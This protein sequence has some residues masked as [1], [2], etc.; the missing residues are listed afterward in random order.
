M[1]A[2]GQLA[3]G[4]AHDF[5]NL[6]TAIV[7][8]TEFSL[9][10]AEKDE[11]LTADL[12][13][14]QDA[15]NRARGLTAQLLAF[16][17]Q[18]M[19]QPRSLCLNDT[20]SG[21]VT[22]LRRLIG[23]H[24]EFQTHFEPALKSVLADPGQIEQVLVNL[25]VNARDAMPQGGTMTIETQNI[26][27]DRDLGSLAPGDYVALV[28]SDTGEGMAAKTMARIFDPFYTTKE[29]GQGT[30]LG[31]STV[32]GIIAQSGGDVTVYS[33]LGVGTTFRLYLPCADQPTKTQEDT[34]MQNKTGGAE[35]I[36][37]V[38][39]EDVVRRLVRQMLERQGYNVVDAPD[40]EVALEIAAVQGDTF[41]LLVTDVVMPKMNGRELASQ[42]VAQHPS[43][44]VLYTSGYTANAIKTNGQ[45]D[46]DMVML[47]KPFTMTDL[48]TKVREILDASV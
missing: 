44:K 3:G 23:E 7:G 10:R 37:L 22:L 9:E 36:L 20:V 6:L 39:D 47:Q 21:T 18:Q 5:N 16:S 33:E 34:E 25:A 31:L 11:I 8:Y 38:E 42:L 2:I 1:E 32:Y 46:P 19:M 48:A 30:G 26:T 43:L 15:A 35:S 17:R 45:L 4:V 27:L 24:I 41:D 40:P 29:V 14:I 13:E 28:V 12:K